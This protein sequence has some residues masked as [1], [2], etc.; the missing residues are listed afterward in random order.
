MFPTL[1]F[2]D[3]S[4]FSEHFDRLVHGVRNTERASALRRA[5][6]NYL[7]TE[8]RYAGNLYRES[9]PAN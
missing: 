4:S 6:L 8:D 5:V 7:A 2:L 9:S 3:G 1:P